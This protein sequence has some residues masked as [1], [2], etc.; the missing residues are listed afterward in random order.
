MMRQNHIE[1][2]RNLIKIPY[3]TEFTIPDTSPGYNHVN[4]DFQLS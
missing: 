3:K 2:I 4:K 1:L